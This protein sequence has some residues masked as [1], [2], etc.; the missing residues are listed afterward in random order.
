[1]KKTF[2]NLLVIA[3]KGT[4]MFQIKIEM[5]SHTDEAEA[6]HRFEVLQGMDTMV[7]SQS[8]DCKGFI[9]LMVITNENPRG[10]EVMRYL[11]TEDETHNRHAEISSNNQR[12]TQFKARE[13]EIDAKHEQKK[14]KSLL[15]VVVRLPKFQTANFPKDA[16]IEDLDKPM[17]SSEKMQKE[18]GTFSERK[19]NRHKKNKPTI[20]VSPKVDTKPNNTPARTHKASVKT[21]LKNIL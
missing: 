2:K 13:A 6:L 8:A 9:S 15:A 12:W 11:F 20:N 17:P 1:M 14:P 21:K 10:K 7:V 18:S 16:D 3:S 19:R 4:G 5:G